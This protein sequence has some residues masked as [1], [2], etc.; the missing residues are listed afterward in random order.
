[1]MRGVGGVVVAVA[2]ATWG[3]FCAVAPAAAQVTPGA[4]KAL[5]AIEAEY[6]VKVLKVRAVTVNGRAAFEAIVMNPA[7]NYNEAFQVNRL[8]VDAATG[9]FIQQVRHGAADFTRSAEAPGAEGLAGEDV[10]LASRRKS[11]AR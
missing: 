1:M 6:G 9:E 4:E 2:I 3:A 10:G 5:K 8:V 11:A 7:G